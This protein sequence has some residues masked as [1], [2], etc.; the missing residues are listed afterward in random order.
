M[1][2]FA[3]SHVHR[4]LQALLELPVPVWHHHPLLVDE[5][6]DKLAKRKGAPSLADRRL[7]GED[8]RSLADALRNHRLPAGISLAE[9]LHPAP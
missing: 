5:T 3:A 7:A 8:G 1:D 2:L 9:G 4:L 6:G